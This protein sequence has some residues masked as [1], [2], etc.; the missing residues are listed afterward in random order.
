MRYVDESSDVRFVGAERLCTVL[1]LMDVTGLLGC[2]DVRFFIF[3]YVFV[4]ARVVR[5]YWE[6]CP[7]FIF[8]LARVVFG[9]RVLDE[10]E[11]GVRG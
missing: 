9:M 5:A 4:C 2:R 7:F 3:F 8:V 10:N 11:C 6:V 1:W